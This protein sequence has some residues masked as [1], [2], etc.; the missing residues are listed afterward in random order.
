VGILS[1]SQTGS[2][3]SFS[4]DAFGRNT[5][6]TGPLGSTGYSYDVAGRR[7]QMNYGGGLVI[8]YD[9]LWTLGT[10][11]SASKWHKMTVSNTRTRLR[12]P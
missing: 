11:M 1:A 5:G 6:Q 3:P 2:A 9:Y 4:F 7:T 8:D 12:L 10:M